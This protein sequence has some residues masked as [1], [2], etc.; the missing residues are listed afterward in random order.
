MIL[1]DDGAATVREEVRG[2]GGDLDD[3][4]VG[5]QVAGQDGPAP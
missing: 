3:G 5:T 4:A 1:E 2:G